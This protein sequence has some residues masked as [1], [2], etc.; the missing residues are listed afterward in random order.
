MIR[1]ENVSVSILHLEAF[2]PTAKEMMKKNHIITVKDL[3]DHMDKLSPKEQQ[4]VNYL[5][6]RCNRILNLSNKHQKEPIIYQAKNYQ[7]PSLS[8]VDELNKGRIFITDSPASEEIRTRY[9]EIKDKKI[10][11]IKRELS[12]CTARGDNLLIRNCYGLGQIGA[13]NVVFLV[14]M[15]TE[16]I[17]RQAA[18]TSDREINLFEYQKVE[19]EQLVREEYEKIVDFF[20]ESQEKFI[21]GELSPFQAQR[22]LSSVNKKGVANQRTRN[23]LTDIIVG[24]TTLEELEE[25]THNNYESLKRFVKTR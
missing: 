20:V 13:E 21:W 25:V 6:T 17:E 19:K 4:E 10:S 22:L 12:L 15:Y 11:S 9:K 7:D 8:Y 14:D 24:Y 16:Q 18:L 3:M 5:L 2:V 23:K 1:L